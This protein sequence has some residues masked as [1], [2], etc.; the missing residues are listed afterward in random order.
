MDDLQ[1]ALL[2]A[3]ESGIPSLVDDVCVKLC[4][5]QKDNVNPGIEPEL[6]D[7]SPYPLLQLMLDYNEFKVLYNSG[8]ITESVSLLSKIIIHRPIPSFFLERIINDAI[9]MNLLEGKKA[10]SLSLDAM[11]RLLEDLDRS[12]NIQDKKTGRLALLRG[13]SQYF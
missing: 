5:E 8:K 6:V 9:S 2:I 13:I 12:A 3:L 1:R 4:L 7:C 11:Y 10:N